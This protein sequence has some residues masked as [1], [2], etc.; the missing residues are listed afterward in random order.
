MRMNNKPI[1]VNKAYAELEEHW[2]IDT[3]D[4]TQWQHNELSHQIAFLSAYGEHGTMN[5]ASEQ[6]GVNIATPHRWR[7]NN[8]FA[9]RDRLAMAHAKFCDSLEDKALELAR[10]LKPGQNSLILVTLLNANLPDKYRPNAVA[11]S[12]TMTETLKAMKQATREFKRLEDGT[13]TVIETET[14]VIVKKGLQG[15]HTATEKE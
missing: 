11:P 1:P 6:I 13:E 5:K 15:P 9:F 8:H 4:L 3:S 14:T 10:G 2:D 12:E 7:K